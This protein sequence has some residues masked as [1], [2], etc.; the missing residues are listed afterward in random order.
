MLKSELSGLEGRVKSELG[1]MEGRVNQ[2]F[3]ETNNHVEQVHRKVASLHEQTAR[4][5]IAARY[6]KRFAKPLHIR[7]VYSLTKHYVGWGLVKAKSGEE[8]CRHEMRIIE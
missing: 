7:G 3:G 4:G 6:G 8:F 5:E 2:R 1:S